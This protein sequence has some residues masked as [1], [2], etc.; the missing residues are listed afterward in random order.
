MTKLRALFIGGNGTISSAASRLAVERGIDLTLLTRGR[1]TWRPPIEG[2]RSVTGDATDASSVA[3][4]VQ[5]DRYDV[6]VDFQLFDADQARDRVA[7]CTGQVGQF[8]YISSAA[9][10]EKPIRRWPIDESTPLRNP[11]WKYAQ[12]KIAAE[13]VFNG[14]F[15]E[16]GFPVTIVRPSHTYDPSLIPLPGGWTML[17]RARRGQPIVIHGDGTS[18]WTL[19]HQADLAVGLVGLLGLPEAIGEAVHITMD[20][21]LTWDAVAEALTVALGVEAT[22]VH[23]GSETLAREIPAWAEPLLGDWRFSELYDNTKI[24]RLVPDYRATIPFVRGARE[25]IDWHLADER[26][27][28]VDAELDA[29]FDSL[30]DRFG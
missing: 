3:R 8:V 4:A 27:Q 26:R 24:K 18:L 28:V 30:V 17:D 10:Y 19:T 12:D 14:A 11:F 2:T 23:V 16:S 15:R 25:I 13:L 1:G 20:T 5:E 29:V 9:A 7:A 22:K 21:A 6:V